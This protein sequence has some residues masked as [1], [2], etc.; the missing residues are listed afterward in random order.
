MQILKA[1]AFYSMQFFCRLW[2]KFELPNLPQAA[3]EKKKAILFTGKN[4]KGYRG[5]PLQSERETAAGFIKIS[6]AAQQTVM[7]WAAS[8][9][10]TGIAWQY[11]Y[12]RRPHF[13]FD[14]LCQNRYCVTVSVLT[15]RPIFYR[16]LQKIHRKKAC[17]YNTDSATQYLF[18]TQLYKPNTK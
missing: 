16:R 4:V 10:I 6:A 5:Q 17:K 9:D 2:K 13:C 15:N 12:W 1:A 3:A 8:F 11:P 14:I 18:C 7:L